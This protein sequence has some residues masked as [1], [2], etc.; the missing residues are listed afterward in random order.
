MTEPPSFIVLIFFTL[1]LSGNAFWSES[2]NFSQQEESERTTGLIIN[3]ES[4]STDGY[5]LVSTFEGTTTQLIDNEGEIMQVWEEPDALAAAGTTLLAVEGTLLESVIVP[6]LFFT[7]LENGGGAIREYDSNGVCIWEFRYSNSLYRLMSAFDTLDNG[8]II[9]ASSQAHTW[10]DASLRGFTGERRSNPDGYWSYT[11][12]EIPRSDMSQRQVNPDFDIN[13][14]ETDGNSLNTC[15]TYSDEFNIVW[16][17]NLFDHSFNP[18]PNPNTWDINLEFNIDSLDFFDTD[19][20]LI[21]CQVCG[22]IFL[23]DHS[24]DPR[25]VSTELG[26]FIFRFGFL[27]NVGAEGDQVLAAASANIVEQGENGFEYEEEDVGTIIIFNNDDPQ[28]EGDISTILQIAPIVIDGEYQVD[29]NGIYST[30]ETI[31][32]VTSVKVEIE[33]KDEPYYGKD[34]SNSGGYNNYYPKYNSNGKS[35]YGRG[36]YGNGW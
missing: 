17:W 35:G 31:R 25:L 19:E 18:I 29:E 22:E 34:K 1:F 24:I 7:D 14:E 21:T 15:Q 10:Y 12:I 11:I 16:K 36:L 8:D 9:A 23:I 28:E 30:P 26:D 33:E 20:I 3:S 27:A 5:N 32:K 4:E 13:A 2:I 6:S